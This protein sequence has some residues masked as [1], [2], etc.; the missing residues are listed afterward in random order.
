MPFGLATAGAYG[1]SD[2][3][4]KTATDRTGFVPTLFFLE[5]FGT[6]FLIGLA[7]FFDAGRP[8]PLGGPL[9]LLVVLS[10]VAVVGAFGLYR[11]FEFGQ[12]SIV[13]PLAS[14]YPA[15]IVVLSVVVLG[16]RLTL[17]TG[18]GVALTILGMLLIARSA[19]SRDTV[20]PPKNARRGLLSA[21]LA[22]FAF[23]AFYFG[24]KFVVG[25]IPPVS[26][27]AIA[28]G[29]GCVTVLGYVAVTRTF[30]VLREKVWGRWAGI[31]VLD[32]SANVFYNLGVAFSRSL[33]ILATLSGLFSAVTVAMA[34]GF[35]GERLT[36][37]QWAGVAAIFVGVALLSY[38]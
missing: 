18:L 13:S 19:P 36:R 6:P 26:A 23:A 29:V 32:S 15:L 25:P 17:A 14:G 30:P 21:L 4:A 27:A 37:V 33:A 1:T 34:M 3:L 35:L 8:I 31:A 16:E 2:F 22:F 24:L 9:V 38:F 5:L 10:V 11:S 20:S 7:W 28:R 12:L